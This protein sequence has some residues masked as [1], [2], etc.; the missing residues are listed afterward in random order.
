MAGC[1][2]TSSCCENGAARTGTRAS[3]RAPR[4]AARGA[5][6]LGP[7]AD[8]GRYAY[9]LARLSRTIW[10]LNQGAEAVPPPS[11]A[12]DLPDDESAGVR[13]LILGMGG[14]DAAAAGATSREAVADGEPALELAIDGG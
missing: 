5:A 7:T 10:R 13:S 9:L 12:R 6:E 4:A 11:G 8:P 3:A 2:T 1:R 14:A